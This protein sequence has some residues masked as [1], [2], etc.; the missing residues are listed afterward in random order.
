ALA[1]EGQ[2][3]GE[4]RE[5]RANLITNY[6]FDPDSTLGGWSIGGAIRWEDDKAVGYPITSQ[7][8]DGQSLNLP[9]LSNPYLDD[10]VERVDFWIGYRTKIFDDKVDWKIQL[11]MANVLKNDGEI[12]TTAVQP[13]GQQRAVTWREGRQFRLRSTFSF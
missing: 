1:R 13:N 9:D 5:W 10:P 3:E 4:L 8:L 11:N 6:R 7:T 2:L 12:I